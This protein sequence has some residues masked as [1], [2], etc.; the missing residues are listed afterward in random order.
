MLLQDILGHLISIVGDQSRI[1]KISSVT[2]KLRTFLSHFQH[3]RFRIGLTVGLSCVLYH[4]QLILGTENQF[5]YGFAFLHI[6]YN[7][8]K[9]DVT[10]GGDKAKSAW[11]YK[12]E[13]S[14]D[15]TNWDVIWD[16]TANEEVASTQKV[17]LD[18]SITEKKY[19]YVRF[20]FGDTIEDAWPAV[21]EFNV[22][23]P[24]ELTNF[25][26]DGEATASTVS[27]DPA[28]A[29]DGN[30]GTLW[31]GDGDS[32]KEGAWW[33]VDLG[34]AQQ[35]QAFDLVF[36]HEVLPTLED[37]QAATTPAYGQAWQYK[38]EGS[39]DKS[40]WDMLWDN[41]ANTD[42]SKEQYGKIAAE[43]ANNK[44]QYVRVT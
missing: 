37:A 35:I 32:E 25:A 30:D 4:L 40:S 23:R 1:P 41:T 16:Q 11:K 44:Y 39:N 42:F 18:E 9:L 38:V 26:L 36:E 22:Y 13:A 33:M 14:T 17:T 21:A 31:V 19:S 28:N 6:S 27:R 20:T 24:K 7:I 10:F 12:V 15:K 2:I 29:I 3:H 5:I 43:Y 8:E 34:K